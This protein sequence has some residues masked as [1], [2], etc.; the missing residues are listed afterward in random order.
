MGHRDGLPQ[1]C[2]ITRFSSPAALVWSSHIERTHQGMVLLELITRKK[3][4][5]NGFA[6]RTPAKLFALE[7]EEI[8]QEAPPD[9]PDS[10]LNLAAMWVHRAEMFRVSERCGWP[11]PS[12]GCVYY[13]VLQVRLVQRSAVTFTTFWA[14]EI[15]RCTRHRYPSST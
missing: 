12:Y 5:E 8:R 7:A 3:I 10:L 4:G 9:A 2:L 13:T 15:E 6:R 1:L 11:E 14:L